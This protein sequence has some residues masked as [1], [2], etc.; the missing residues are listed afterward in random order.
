MSLATFLQ[1]RRWFPD[2]EDAWLNELASDCNSVLS[3]LP[4]EP[5]HRKS[6]FRLF[7][8]VRSVLAMRQR[9]GQ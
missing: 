7:D 6:K 9:E 2:A 5:D 4:A 1:L 3:R 8:V